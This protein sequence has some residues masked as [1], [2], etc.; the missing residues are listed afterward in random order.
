MQSCKWIEIYTCVLVNYLNQLNQTYILFFSAS[1]DACAAEWPEVYLTPDQLGDEAVLLG[2]GA[3]E[4]D[5]WAAGA[6]KGL[7]KWVVTTSIIVE[8][9]IN[10]ARRTKN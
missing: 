10:P 3:S 2:L 5:T 4:P 6:P 9:K 1:D 8:R 7:A